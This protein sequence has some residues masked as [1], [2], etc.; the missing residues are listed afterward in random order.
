MKKYILQYD[1][2]IS[3]YQLWTLTN[4]NKYREVCSSWYGSYDF[5]TLLSKE[6]EYSYIVTITDNLTDI[7]S[8]GD[9][10]KTTRSKQPFIWDGVRPLKAKNIEKIWKKFY[11]DWKLTYEINDREGKIWQFPW[12]K[13]KRELEELMNK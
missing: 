6:S 5:E 7:I 4:E 12:R 3:H 2:F 8:K 1:Y 9:M 13:T 10:V 11:D